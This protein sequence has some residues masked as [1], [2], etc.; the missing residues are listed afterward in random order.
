MLIPYSRQAATDYCSKKGK[1]IMKFVT[2]DQLHN[3]FCSIS[4]AKVCGYDA[5]EL[6]AV[7]G[8]LSICPGCIEIP[9]DNDTQIE[10][11]KLLEEDAACLQTELAIEQSWE[12]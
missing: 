1:H 10:Q 12:G 4:C 6:Q 5:K 3:Q 2:T 8:N 11:N 7:D 9:V